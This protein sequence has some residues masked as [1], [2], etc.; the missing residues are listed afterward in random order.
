M[1]TTKAE[2]FATKMEELDKSYQLLLARRDL[3]N[4][5]IADKEAEIQAFLDMCAGV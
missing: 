4:Q 2:D 1:K 3:L 5:A